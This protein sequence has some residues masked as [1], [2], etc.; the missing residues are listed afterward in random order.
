MIFKLKSNIEPLPQML[1]D[2]GHAGNPAVAHF[3]IFFEFAVAQ[4]KAGGPGTDNLLFQPSLNEVAEDGIAG[5]EILGAVVKN[6]FIHA[7]G[8]E[9][10]A[11]PAPFINDHDAIAAGGQG[12][13]GE[14]SAN[15]CANHNH[16]SFRFRIRHKNTQQA[17]EKLHRRFDDEVNGCFRRM[18]TVATT[19]ELIDAMADIIDVH[20]LATVERICGVAPGATQI[21]AR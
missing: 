9:T 2:A 21:A 4:R 3:S 6:G 19:G 5:G 18:L 20:A 12:S 17:G 14:Q 16:I 8:G 13:R 10:A 1:G 7:A 15:A 11:D